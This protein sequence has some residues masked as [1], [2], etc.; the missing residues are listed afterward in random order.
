MANESI[1][2][3]INSYKARG[4]SVMFAARYEDGRT[5]YFVIEGH[6]TSDEDYLALEVARERQGTGELPAGVIVS[7]KRV[8]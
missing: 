3:R 7:A 6:G 2:R 8:R 4:K 5:G 1:Q